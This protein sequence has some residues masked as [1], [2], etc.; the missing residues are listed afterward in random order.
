MFTPL[1]GYLTSVG[2]SVPLVLQ[3]SARAA[4]F[5]AAAQ[6]GRSRL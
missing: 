2:A 4:V 5:R 1:T 6:A 3:R